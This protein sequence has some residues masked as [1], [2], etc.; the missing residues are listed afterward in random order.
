M[1]QRRI[2]S[3]LNPLAALGGALP[4]ASGGARLNKG[5]RKL[6]KHIKLGKI[7]EV[8]EFIRSSTTPGMS[9]KAVLK[10]FPE[11]IKWRRFSAARWVRKYDKYKLDKM[12]P[13]ILDETRIPY[14]WMRRCDPSAKRGGKACDFTMPESVQQHLDKLYGQRAVGAPGG[15]TVPVTRSVLCRTV[16]I[17][18]AKFAIEAAQREKV[19]VEGQKV[20]RC[21]LEEGEISPEEAVKR[22]NA[23]P[24]TNPFRGTFSRRWATRFKKRWGWGHRSVNTAGLYMDYDSPVMVKARGEED[25]RF[26]AENTDRRLFIIYDQIWEQPWRGKKRVDHKDR[27]AVGAQPRRKVSRAAAKEYA[28]AGLPRELEPGAYELSAEVEG[29][30]SGGR[31]AAKA[32]TF[33]STL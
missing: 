23:R 33:G 13:W 1:P 11:S 27:E 22:L 25:L 28:V 2:R 4:A 32:T 19:R 10:Q 29:A 20:V 14:E 3:K 12:P 26:E 7:K 9:G 6:C 31:P 15:E 21:L 17:W 16:K 24:V 8:V 5:S 30:S 18:K